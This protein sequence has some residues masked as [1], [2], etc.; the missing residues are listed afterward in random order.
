MWSATS[1]AHTHSMTPT[2]Y[3]TPDLVAEHRAS[4]EDAARRYRATHTLRRIWRRK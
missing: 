1:E 3:S 4:L 2:W